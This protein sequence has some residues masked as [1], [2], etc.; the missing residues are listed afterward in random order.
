MESFWDG[1]A[2]SSPVQ[3]LVSEA[4]IVDDPAAIDVPGRILQPLMLS[5][6]TA[7]MIKNWQF[8]CRQNH[9][10]YQ[11][12]AYRP[13]R[14]LQVGGGEVNHLKLQACH[15]SSVPSLPEYAALSYMW[16]G[17]QRFMTTKDSLEARMVR[18]EF[19]D[20]P[21]TLRDAVL[22]CRV[23]GI[24][25][26][27]VDV[28]CIIQDDPQDKLEQIKTMGEV[29]RSAALTIIPAFSLGSDEGFLSETFENVTL[30][31]Q[32]FRDNTSSGR[33]GSIYLIK[34]QLDAPRFPIETRGWTMQERLLSTRLLFFHPGRI[35][36]VC[37]ES[38]LFAG[39]SS[40]YSVNMIDESVTDRSWDKWNL[41]CSNIKNDDVNLQ[42]QRWYTLS[43]AFS[44]R[45]LSDP[46]DRLPALASVA[47]ELRREFPGIGDYVAGL[48]TTNLAQQLLWKLHLYTQPKSRLN[49]FIGPS[50]SW[51]SIESSFMLPTFAIAPADIRL[52]ILD[53]EI[54]HDISSDRY[55]SLLAAS[56]EVRGRLKTAQWNIS[57]QKIES[58]NGLLLAGNT[59][60]VAD[61]KDYASRGP[62]VGNIVNVYC[63]EVQDARYWARDIKTEGGQVFT[64]L[65]LF[66]C[67]GARSTYRRAGLFSLAKVDQDESSYA[68]FEAAVKNLA[69][70]EDV[71]PQVITII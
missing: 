32:C 21:G 7:A 35:D 41:N 55:G 31:F 6:D 4:N 14:L 53:Y 57:T 26:L 29:Y 37:R 25:W 8:T 49:K 47:K 23:I 3:N 52:E 64:G 51:V 27:W 22:V 36:W 33:Q 45:T 24:R 5:G 65:L 62:L 34:K 42:I 28:L 54:Q 2:K 48:W 18:I 69:W 56:L 11:R 63:L 44:E 17:P 19:E 30:P 38:H 40:S 58:S 20:L 46:L 66:K 59:K 60:T 16:G 15:E 13:Q 43:Q 70:F 10:D 39:S 71:E 61:S 68:V 67:P 50:W 1:N 9:S 12:P